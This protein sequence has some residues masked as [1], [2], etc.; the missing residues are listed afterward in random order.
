MV[1]ACE[2]TLDIKVAQYATQQLTLSTRSQFFFG[3]FIHPLLML[4]ASLLISPLTYVQVLHV[5][6]HLFGRTLE[7][8]NKFIKVIEYENV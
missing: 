7:N 5:M 8:Y 3:T 2:T 1:D 4:T 6:Q